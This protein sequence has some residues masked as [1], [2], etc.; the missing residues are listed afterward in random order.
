MPR[1]GKDEEYD[2]IMAQINELEETLDKELKRLEKKL[3]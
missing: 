3:G 1:E 2:G